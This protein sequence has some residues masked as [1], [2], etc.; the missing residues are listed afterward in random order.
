MSQLFYH[1]LWGPKD[2]LRHVRNTVAHLYFIVGL[3]MDQIAIDLD[4]QPVK[5][6]MCLD[7]IR[8]DRAPMG[9]AQ[10]PEIPEKYYG[11]PVIT[12]DDL[13]QDLKKIEKEI[14]Q[15]EIYL[16]ALINGDR[17]PKYH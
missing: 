14:K 7:R 10:E 6:R 8:A 13:K 4:M 16:T 11:M 5:V 9:R 1:K 17:L 2:R 12:M 3:T 15:N